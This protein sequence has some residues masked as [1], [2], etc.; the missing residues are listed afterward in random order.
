M[1]VQLGKKVWKGKK[2]LTF[3][4]HILLSLSPKYSIEI[5]ST[6]KVLIL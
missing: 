5:I 2:L 6:D 1:S 3:V 4:H